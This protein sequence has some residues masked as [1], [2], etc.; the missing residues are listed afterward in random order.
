MGFTDKVSNSAQDG[1][2]RAK[3]AAGDL[4]DNRDLQAEGKADQSEASLKKAGENIKDAF[5]K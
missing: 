1:T 2:G 5:K 3:E 4:T